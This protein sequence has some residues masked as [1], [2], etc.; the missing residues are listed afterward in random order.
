MVEDRVATGLK[1]LLDG[2]DWLKDNGYKTVLHVH[3][4]GE[5]DAADRR[6][7]EKRGLKYLGLEISA[8]ALTRT[9]LDDFNHIVGDSAARPLFVYDRDGSL[10][11]ALWYL[12]FRTIGQETDRDARVKAGRL[13]LKDDQTEEGKLL[14]LAIQ[15][16]LGELKL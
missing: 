5:E 1:P 8:Q 12:H 6:Q 2:L 11:G 10:G 14:W 3:L 9:Q 4:P 15:R 13:G 16:V 7:V